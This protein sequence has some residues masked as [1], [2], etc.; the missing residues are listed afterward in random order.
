MKMEDCVVEY[1]IAGVGWQYFR[2]EPFI[3][4]KGI[5]RYLWEVSDLVLPM[6]RVYFWIALST[7]T[8]GACPWF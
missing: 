1:L 5:H 3:F 4:E 6:P 2:L 8:G 7:S